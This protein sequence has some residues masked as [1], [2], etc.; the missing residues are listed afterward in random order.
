MND[1]LYAGNKVL[2]LVLILSAGP[3]FVAT[4]VGLLVGLIQ[5]VTQLQE[6]TLPFGIKLLSVTLCL[7][8]LSGWYGEILLAYGREVVRLALSR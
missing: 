2:Y 8:L 6:Q 1:M 4:V 7:F 5:T 3:I